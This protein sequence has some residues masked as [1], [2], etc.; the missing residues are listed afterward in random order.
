[1]SDNPKLF[2]EKA[3]GV[4][5]VGP[6]SPALEQRALAHLLTATPDPLVLLHRLAGDYRPLV[7]DNHIDLFRYLRPSGGEE[8]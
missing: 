7:V 4:R 6:A 5:V 1:M 8:R 3:I 2:T